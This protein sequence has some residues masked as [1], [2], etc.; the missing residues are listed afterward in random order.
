MLV[1]RAELGELQPAFSVDAHVCTQCGL[2]E[3]P[4]E[5]PPDFFVRHLRLTPPAEDSAEMHQALASIIGAVGAG[6]LIV[7][8]IDTVGRNLATREGAADHAVPQNSRWQDVPIARFGPSLA[9]EIMEAAGVAK[10]LLCRHLLEQVSELHEFMEGVARLLAPGGVL[11]VETAWAHEVLRQNGFNRLSAEHISIFSL[12]SLVKLCAFFDLAV[13][14][15]RH[16]SANGGGLRVQIGQLGEEVHPSVRATIAQ[17][18]AAGCLDPATYDNFAA[19]VF[20]IRDKLLSILWQT[21]AQGLR[22]AGLGA[23]EDGHALLNFCGIGRMEVEFLADPDPAKLETFSPGMKIPIRPI[24]AIAT[25]R[26]D[27]LMV[28]ADDPRLAQHG[29]GALRQPPR[30]LRPLPVPTF[31]N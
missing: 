28:L 19:R 8:F 29:I 6:D 1:R 15:V 14:D 16:L 27:L 26:P 4:R 24:S 2:I 17:E 10:I 31:V 5:M 11:I 7:N 25:E 30:L 12:V 20:D 21:K 22:L 13:L 9:R 23:C 3:V 18:I